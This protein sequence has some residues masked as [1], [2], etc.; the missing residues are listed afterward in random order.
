MK[1]NQRRKDKKLPN[2]DGDLRMRGTKQE[3]NPKAC[4]ENLSLLCPE[5]SGTVFSILFLWCYRTQNLLLVHRIKHLGLYSVYTAE[6]VAQWRFQ[7]HSFD[8]TDPGRLPWWPRESKKQVFVFPM[9]WQ[10]ILRNLRPYQ[11]TIDLTKNII[12]YRLT[13]SLN[14]EA[15][16][17]SNSGWQGP[18]SVWHQNYLDHT[19][20]STTKQNGRLCPDVP[21][22]HK[23]FRADR[24]HITPDYVC[25]SLRGSS[26][27]L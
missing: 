11:I 24:C 14:I 22:F 12:Y 18:C 2:T 9:P 20:F 21:T 10:M 5:S 3:W 25:S 26:V 27:Y 17:L 23:S 15:I 13:S 7:D 4:E 6:K 16:C 19:P 1:G 8:C